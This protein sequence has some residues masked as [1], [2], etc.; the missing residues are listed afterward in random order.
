MRVKQTIQNTCLCN[1]FSFYILSCPRLYT[2]LYTHI[3][4]P[5]F[6]HSLIYTTQPPHIL[7]HP[8]ILLYTL[9]YSLIYP[10]CTLSYILLYILLYILSTL[11]FSNSIIN[12]APAVLYLLSLSYIL[13]PLIFISLLFSYSSTLIFFYSLIQKGYNYAAADFYTLYI[14]ILIST[15]ALISQLSYYIT[16]KEWKRRRQELQN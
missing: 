15:A 10:L 4:L 7:H 3:F 13:A 5:P 8:Y 12:L 2:L 16:F 14:A 1:R 11:L 9:I 6:I